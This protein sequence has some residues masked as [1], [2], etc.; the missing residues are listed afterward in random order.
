MK[1]YH[2]QAWY[3]PKGRLQFLADCKFFKKI[4]RTADSSQHQGGLLMLDTKKK[5]QGCSRC[6]RGPL[7]IPPDVDRR[8]TECK[9]LIL[10]SS[11]NPRLG[12]YMYIYIYWIYIYIGVKSPE[13]PA[14]RTINKLEMPS[15]K[16]PRTSR[17][18][19]VIWLDQPCC[20]GVS[21]SGEGGG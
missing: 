9:L 3:V 10:R 20:R 6:F 5:V 7:I 12:I 2:A 1:T 8:Q 21:L 19:E 18:S 11:R 14:W 17:I 13:R 16:P 15:L 4:R